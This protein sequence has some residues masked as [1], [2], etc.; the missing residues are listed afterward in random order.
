MG[1]CMQ[2]LG[3][4]GRHMARGQAVLR[5]LRRGLFG[6]RPMPGQPPE[7]ITGRCCPPGMQPGGCSRPASKPGRVTSCM[8]ARGSSRPAGTH[9]GWPARGVGAAR[10]LP[11]SRAVHG[12]PRPRTAHPAGRG[13]PGP[14]PAWV[15]GVCCVWQETMHAGPPTSS[16]GVRVCQQAA[17]G[18]KSMQSLQDAAEPASALRQWAAEQHKR[19]AAAASCQPAAG[20]R[21]MRDAL[22]M[23][24]PGPTPPAASPRGSGCAGGGGRACCAPCAPLL[25]PAAARS[26][27]QSRA[28][29]CRYCRG[30]R[31]VM[32]K[33]LRSGAGTR[34]QGGQGGRGAPAQLWTVRQLVPWGPNKSACPRTPWQP[35]Q[36]T[37]RAP[38]LPAHPGL[39]KMK[40]SMP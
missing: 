33:E 40:S 29:R 34:K 31:G 23:P 24:A 8:S 3:R 38:A 6:A 2:W 4:V 10:R 7:G 35:Q 11:G 27:G 28:A 32:G 5:W 39:L 26:C 15:W 30:A 37:C 22:G 25:C 17:Q 14:P 1:V 21:R 36:Q 13:P 16:A 18:R 12:G 19:H 9:P 20:R